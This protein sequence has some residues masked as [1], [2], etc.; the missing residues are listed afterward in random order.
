MLIEIDTG[1][2]DEGRP[3]YDGETKATMSNDGV[4]LIEPLYGCEISTL[5]PK[6]FRAK[7]I[8]HGC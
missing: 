3:T 5:S 6:N 7:A 8:Q 2:R 4:R 1:G